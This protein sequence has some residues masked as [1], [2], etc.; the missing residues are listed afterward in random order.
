MTIEKV[1]IESKHIVGLATRTNNT[2]EKSATNG[3]IMQ[4]WNSFFKN[5]VEDEIKRKKKNKIFY[6]VYSNYESDFSGDYDFHAGVEAQH[7]KIHFQEVKIEA[8]DYLLF[9]NNG[10][11][12]NVVFETWKAVWDYFEDESNKEIRKYSTDFEQYDQEFQDQVEIYISIK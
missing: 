4:L 12:P 5:N 7:N 11:M 6:G 2:I 8:G 3:K 1:T 10:E 9:K